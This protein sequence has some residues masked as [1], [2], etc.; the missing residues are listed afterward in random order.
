MIDVQMRNHLVLV[1]AFVE[2]CLFKAN[3]E[4]L[5]VIVELAGDFGR[6]AGGIQPTAEV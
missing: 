6:D 2:G 3:S 5:Q 1:N 4:G